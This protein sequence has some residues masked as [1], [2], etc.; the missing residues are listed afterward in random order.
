MQ[1]SDES[2]VVKYG[3]LT[4]GQELNCPHKVRFS[5][6]IELILILHAPSLLFQMKCFPTHGLEDVVQDVCQQDH[7][8]QHDRISSYGNS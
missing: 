4:S 7:L 1:Q 3:T 5:T 2:A 8:T 6:R